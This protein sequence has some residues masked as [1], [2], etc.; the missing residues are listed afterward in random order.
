MTMSELQNAARDL[1]AGY[2]AIGMSA[3]E[4]ATLLALAL[5]AIV[6]DPETDPDT[7][8]VLASVHLR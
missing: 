3:R 5:H 2:K 8:A 4:I 1:V 7:L 6:L